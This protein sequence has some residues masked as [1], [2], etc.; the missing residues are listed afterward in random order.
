MSKRDRSMHETAG[1][2]MPRYRS[3]LIEASG[4]LPDVD[5]DAF[6]AR[7]AARAELSLAR[8]R[9]PHVGAHT[10]ARPL[11]ARY[12]PFTTTRAWWEYA[13]R[14]SRLTITA[15]AAAGIVLVAVVR[16]YPKEVPETVVATT[17][18]TA[19][20]LERTR[21]AFES[22]ATGRNSAW[23]M[24]SALLPNAAELLIPLG[25]RSPAQ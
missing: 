6:H 4:R 21:A 3:A 22:A 23:T 12:I 5:W 20:Q 18:A 16:M 13:A 8:L 11:P 2:E 9:Y 7:L 24:E 1:E 10:S 25:K 19:D 15:S 14:W 17:V